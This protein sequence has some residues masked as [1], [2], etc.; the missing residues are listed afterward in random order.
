MSIDLDHLSL[1][2][3]PSIVKKVGRPKKIKDKQY[4]SNKLDQRSADLKDKAEKDLC[5]FI[6]LVHPN[7]ILGRIHEELISWMTR[8]GKKT[9]QLVL[10]PRDHQKSAMAAY[11]AA[12]RITQ[13]PSIRILYISSTSNL[14]TKQLKFIK[15][16]LTSDTYRYYW[17]D[18]VNL[19]ESKREKW[20]NT[21]ISVDHPKR[22]E[23]LIRDPTIFTAGLTTGIVGLH[24]DLAVLDDVVTGHNS[25]QEEGRDKVRTQVSYLSSISGA[26]GEQLTVGTRYH[27]KDLYNDMLEIK[28]ETFDE[29]GDIIGSEELYEVF[30][31]KVED[32]GDGTG[33]FIWP[34]QQSENGK[35]FG[36][37]T[38]ILS[39][40]RAQYSDIHKFRA[41]YYNSPNLSGTGSI[42]P[43]M[44]QYYN[45]SFIKQVGLNWYYN[46]NRLNVSAAVDFAYST[47]KTADFT[48][49]V[50]VG[51][52]INN[53][54]YVLD[55]DRFKTSM[56]SEYYEH[57]L[58]LHTK[59]GFRK[60]R[61]EITAAQ[62]VIVRDLKDNYI[63][64]N[65]L[66]LVL[67]EYRPVTRKEERIEAVL[68]PKYS[69][70][71]MW[72]YVGG[73]CEILEEEL[74]L[75]RPP[76]DDIKDSLSS[77]IETLVAPSG[78]FNSGKPKMLQKDSYE[79]KPYFNS[80]FGGVS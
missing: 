22:K 37:N 76:H 60:I 47:R 35:W 59:W 58:R 21:E 69:N 5:F 52:D 9:H 72:H 16:I 63:R 2:S 54:Y 13:N 49:I 79:L 41:Q 28:F 24:C 77:C 3:D 27:P 40:K 45:R 14:A 46:N 18:M 43:E 67:D 66:S 38:D 39:R 80:R 34:R 25:E 11:Y 30:E 62:S 55:I 15:D 75:V 70:R 26:D 12:W 42:K 8:D 65:G 53:N 1:L 64:P 57:I 48:S 31:R 56:I 17:P 51:I 23:D 73:N 20:T 33:N 7:R 61:A 32:R 78:S 10:L 44:F 68:Q 71:Q 74:C 4:L 50:V 36:F 29:K 19:E 6:K